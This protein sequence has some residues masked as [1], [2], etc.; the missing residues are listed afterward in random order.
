MSAIEKL[1]QVMR[2]LRDPESGCPWDLRQTSASIAPY[3]LD[4]TH[5]LLDAIERDDTENLREELGDLLFNIVFHARIAEEK[6]QFDFDDVAQGIADKMLR[7]HPHVFG[8]QSGERVSDEDLSQQ[9][10]ALKQQEK[11]QRQASTP[12]ADLTSSSAMYRARQ[13]QQEAAG[14]GFDWPDIN[15][16]FDKLE[17]ELAELKHAFSTG[18]KDAVSDELGDL[19]FV[20][21]NLARHAGVNAEMSLRRTNRKFLRRFA[22]VQSQMAAA[23]IEMDQQQLEKM[24]LFWQESKDLVG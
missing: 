14:F 19:L 2:D 24:E 16:V 6:G 21:V 5:E 20:C 9:W 13:I 11:S 3:T 17:E 10:Q 4:E 12:G 23:G 8:D 1:L 7:R 18:D 22:H 15:P